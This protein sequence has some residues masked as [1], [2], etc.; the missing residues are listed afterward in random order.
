MISL[1]RYSL[2]NPDISGRETKN[3]EQSVFLTVSDCP[4]I[5]GLVSDLLPMTLPH[6]HFQETSEL[7]SLEVTTQLVVP[8]DMA[9]FPTYLNLFPI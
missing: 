6:H 2:G 3:K 8:S 9:S 4:L 5:S 1:Q 7:G